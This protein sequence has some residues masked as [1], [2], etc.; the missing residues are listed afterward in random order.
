M[1]Y[2]LIMHT[3]CNLSCNYCDR[4]NFSSPDEELYDYN[5]PQTI[6]YD[7]S[8]LQKQIKKEDYITFYGGEPLLAIPKIKKIMDSISCKGFMLQTNG[9]FLNKIEKEYLERFHTILVSIDGDAEATERNRGKGIHEKI[10]KNISYIKEKGFKGELIA[11]MTITKNSSIYNQVRW[12]LKNG[13]ENIH[14]QIDGMF[15]ENSPYDWYEQYNQEIKMLLDYWMEELKQGRVH[16]LYPF[17]VLADS[18]RKKEKVLLRCGA[19]FANYTITTNGKIAPCPIMGSMRKYYCGELNIP[20]KRMF[21]KSP[22]AECDILEKC[23]GRC[24]YVNLTQYGGKKA[25]TSLCATVRFLITNMEERLPEIEELLRSGVITSKQ[26]AYLKYNG[27][28]VIP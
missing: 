27:V 8:E 25:Y 23:G 21:V 15:Y 6:S 14:W 17:L 5:S 7:I 16:R 20:L 24:L 22:C 2:H 9:I 11:R 4:D 13:F 26:F 12:L 1:F 19:G 10:I 28:E 18:L 3:A